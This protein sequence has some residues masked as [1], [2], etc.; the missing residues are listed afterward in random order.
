MVPPN[1]T[2]LDRTATYRGAFDSSLTTL[3]VDNWTVLSIAG[4]IDN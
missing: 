4:L 3:W 2:L 1:G